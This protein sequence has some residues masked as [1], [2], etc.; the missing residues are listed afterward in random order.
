MVELMV[1][2]ILVAKQFD[3]NERVKGISI[4]ILLIESL[5]SILLANL[6]LLFNWTV[7]KQYFEL[8]MSICTRLEV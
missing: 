4:K 7:K 5:I 3:S 8:I 6:R 2:N 1:E